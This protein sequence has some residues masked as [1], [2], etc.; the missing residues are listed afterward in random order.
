MQ[1]MSDLITV[2]ESVKD[3][4]KR[5]E[6]I[7]RRIRKLDNVKLKHVLCLENEFEDIKA[8][9]KRIEL[10]LEEIQEVVFEVKQNG[11]KR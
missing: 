7:D 6:K 8:L 11:S 4:E 2:S 1:G 10:H 3:F 9:L 5:L